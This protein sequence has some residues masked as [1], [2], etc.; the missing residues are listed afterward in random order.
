MRAK[1]AHFNSIGIIGCNDFEGINN[2][3]A[4]T[5]NRAMQSCGHLLFVI[6]GFMISCGNKQG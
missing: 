4:W 3:V 1:I 6:S 5:T 2:I